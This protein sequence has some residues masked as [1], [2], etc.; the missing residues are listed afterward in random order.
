[1]H[2]TLHITRN[3]NLRCDYCYAPPQGDHGMSLDTAK[4][5]LR[6]GAEST[7]GS[8]GIIFFGGEPLLQRQLILDT[9]AA[10]KELSKSGEGMFHFKITTNGV[11]LDHEF[12]D[13]SL[14][15]DLLIAMSLDGIREAHNLHRRLPGGGG[16]FDAIYPKFKMLLD[17][18]PYSSILSVINPDTVEH[19][20]DSVEFLLDEGARYLIMSLNY[21]AK[22]TEEDFGRLK[23]QF[24]ILGE[25]YIKWTREGRKF[26]FSPFE[27]KLASRIQDD[28]SKCLR[29]ELGERQLAVDPDGYIY[30]CVQFT[31]AGPQSEWKIGHVREGLDEMARIAIHGRSSG[32]KEPCD[33]C[34]L[35][36]RCHNT[37]GCLNWQTTGSV[38]QISGVL[39]AYE[40][41]VIPIADR[42][43]EVLY[44]ERNP[45]FLEKHYNP[46]YPLVSLM[47]DRM[48]D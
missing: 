8:C 18:R 25:R 23:D 29:C 45:L 3:C 20:V 43:G 10:A 24:D 6:F 4:D 46:A 13:F 41:M 21:D 14:E 9:V 36:T 22:W 31:A 11:L 32:M 47:E 40:R 44:A 15:N 17:A 28:A 12:L 37:C 39:C 19:L 27:T 38:D 35:N 1:M 26:Y 7:N 33:S 30:P 48:E 34:D 42:V 16:T 5:C 2:L